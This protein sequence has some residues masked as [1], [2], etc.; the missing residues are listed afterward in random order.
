M[1]KTTKV[2]CRAPS[3]LT[4]FHFTENT[5]KA[6]S[7]HYRFRSVFPIH[8]K[9]LEYADTRHTLNV[10]A[11]SCQPPSSNETL[12]EAAASLCEIQEKSMVL[13]QPG[14]IQNLLGLWYSVTEGCWLYLIFEST[15]F[16]KEDVL[17][18]WEINKR[19]NG[20]MINSR[21]VIKLESKESTSTSMLST[22]LDSSLPRRL[23]LSSCDVNDISVF[24]ASVFAVYTE[25][26]AYSKQCVFKCLQFGEHFQ[27]YVFTMK[28]IECSHWNV[29]ISKWKRVSV[30][31]T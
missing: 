27:M 1:I 15:I 3:T 11:I 2:Q 12:K 8:A 19:L 25:S 21:Q 22:I 4:R 20:A 7:S 23:D 6:L 29:C 9:T 5:S 13:L 17:L 10:W 14:W 24:K 28:T 31:R 26:D 16:L 30:D 18:L